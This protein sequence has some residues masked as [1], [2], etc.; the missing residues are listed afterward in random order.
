M[1]VDMMV[2][3]SRREVT[4]AVCEPHPPYNGPLPI[5]ACSAEHREITLDIMNV[6]DAELQGQEM[7]MQSPAEWNT[8]TAS[9]D[10][11]GGSL[12][13]H[14]VHA[15]RVRE[16]EYLRLRQVY[17]Y[18]TTR[19]A[20]RLTGKQPLG[21]RWIDTNKGGRTN[22]NIRAR[23]VATEVRRR[24]V[25][26]IFCA[27]PPLESVRVLLAKLTSESPDSVGDPLRVAL[28]DVS[29]AHFYAPAVRDV[30]IR[31]PSEDP[32]SATPGACGKLKKTMYGTLDAG[33]QWSVHYTNVLLAAG[34]R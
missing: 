34:F 4:K 9:D 15:A 32:E 8:W 31:L 22:M 17:E 10:V 11:K 5:A 28:A 1:L 33:A 12:P 20:L 23:L 14:L 16:L 27:A 2:F 21:L 25:E 19:E 18:S 6:E 26:S 29:R 30:F 13:A 3:T 7:A 24:G